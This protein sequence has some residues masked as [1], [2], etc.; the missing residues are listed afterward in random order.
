MAET[1]ETEQKINQL[2]LLEQNLQNL[3]MQKQQFQTQLIETENA[4][5][6]LETTNQAYKIVSNI[7]VLTNRDDLK[8]DLKE[9]KEMVEIRIKNL[10]KQEEKL[11]QKAKD[12]QKEILGSMKEHEKAK[13]K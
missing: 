13:S 10:E 2:Q 8:K 4:S 1:K 9:R 6:E 12:L 11:R 7:M 3:S 5:R